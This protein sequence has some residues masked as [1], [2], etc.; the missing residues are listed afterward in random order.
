MMATA[1]RR[2]IQAVIEETRQA[3][4]MFESRLDEFATVLTELEEETRR[5]RAERRKGWQ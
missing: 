2:D 3:L 5:Q 1:G 4:D